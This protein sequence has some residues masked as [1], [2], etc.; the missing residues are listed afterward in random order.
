MLGNLDPAL[1]SRLESISLIALFNTNLLTE[2]SI[3]DILKPF[4]E[5]LKD[6]NTVSL[7]FNVYNYS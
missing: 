1:R 2:Y 7:I 6:L 4:I 5:D 3:D